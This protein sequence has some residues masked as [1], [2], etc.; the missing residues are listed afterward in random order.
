M[1][2]AGLESHVCSP[3]AACKKLIPK[4]FNS[5]HQYSS[6]Y[7]YIFIHSQLSSYSFSLH[8][9]SQVLKGFDIAQA[10]FKRPLNQSLSGIA[11]GISGVCLLLTPIELALKDLE[12]P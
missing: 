9:R 8:L 1:N 4:R 11:Y 6:R 2:T 12:Y 7:S 10:C 5:I 3:H